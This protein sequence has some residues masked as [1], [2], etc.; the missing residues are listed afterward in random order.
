MKTKATAFFKDAIDCA[1]KGDREKTE[2]YLE[3]YES[4]MSD[5]RKQIEDL[6]RSEEQLHREWDAV[7][8]VY[9]ANSK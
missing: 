3:S 1:L 8:V 6:K 7:L 2:L 4:R 5:I 9:G